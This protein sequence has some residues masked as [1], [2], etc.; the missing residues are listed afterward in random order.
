MALLSV[1]EAL[2]RMLEGLTPLEAEDVSLDDAQ[3][4]VLAA[5]LAA[6]V[7]QPPFDA[8]AMDGYAVRGEDVSAP[9][10]TLRM[11]GEAAAGQGFGGEVGGGEAVRIFTGAPVPKGA[12]TIVIQEY[13]EADGANIV[14]KEAEPCR[15]I[16]P[17]GQDFKDGEIL[18]RA[19]TQLEP[20]H[21]MLAAAMNHA[22]LPV[23]RKP[24][25]AILAT[26]N[27][28]MPPGT[29]LSP[30]QIVSSVPAGLVAFVRA[31]GGEALSLGIAKDD[32]NSLATLARAGSAA[33]IL[34]TIGGASVGERD[35]VASA[36]E[37]E[38]LVVDFWKVAVRPG[39]P[40]LSGRMESTRFLGLPGN[41]VS[42]FV[43]AH[44][45]LN[46]ML[47]RLLG[48]DD[49]AEELAWGVLGADLEA[50]GP[51]Q[52]YIR[53]TSAFGEGGRV[54]TA[55]PSQDSSLVAALARADCLIVRSPHAPAGHA[56]DPVKVIP[57]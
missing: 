37:P 24:K 20:R 40:L 16:R 27:E 15:H 7:T 31:A 18:L 28:V 44:V 23:R 56:G 38:G 42:A 52:H 47:R 5:D 36:L 49:A 19:G 13:V 35:L 26:G 6:L 32:P 22:L 29:E 9:P 30:D 14:V 46:P 50:N 10:A 41:P 54:V 33:D 25:V 53:A 12:D 51:R 57:L 39:K 17:R 11:I 43:C 34:V 45:F 48:A 55:L 4:R 1:S 8:S 2:A 3:G 21:L